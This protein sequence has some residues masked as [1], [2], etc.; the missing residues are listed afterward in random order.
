M[1]NIRD[2]QKTIPS[3][4]RS[5]ATICVEHFLNR[6]ISIHV[7]CFARSFEDL[8]Y[9]LVDFYLVIVDC[10]DS[11]K[12]NN[13]DTSA[14][15][16]KSENNV[17]A[18]IKAHVK[19]SQWKDCKSA[20]YSKIKFMLNSVLLYVTAICVKHFLNHLFSNHV[21]CF[22]RSVEDLQYTLTDSYLVIVDCLDSCL[23]SLPGNF[24]KASTCRSFRRSIFLARQPSLLPNHCCPQWGQ[25][26]SLHCFWQHV[27]F[28]K[29]NGILKTMTAIATQ[30]WLDLST[31][32]LNN[33]ARQHTVVECRV[34]L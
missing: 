6:L 4:W 18:W 30:V 21:R 20:K 12:G 3:L 26:S 33:L 16:M 14:E 23:P 25:K 19:I 15:R 13:W 5:S 24:L 7:S 22:A 1:L 11:C 34:A 10:L 9:T 8:Q 27:Q 17:V 29:C 28:G 2:Q 32:A 31:E